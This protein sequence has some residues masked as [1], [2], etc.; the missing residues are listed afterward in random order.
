MGVLFSSEVKTAVDLATDLAAELRSHAIT[1]LYALIFIATIFTFLLNFF[2]LA[3][4][5]LLITINPD[6]AEERKAFV[7]PVVRFLFL[8]LRG[9]RGISART[10]AEMREVAEMFRGEGVGNGDEGPKRRRAAPR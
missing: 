6:L 3:V 5:G 10:R 8:P 9:W 1:A 2:V 7:T 4:I